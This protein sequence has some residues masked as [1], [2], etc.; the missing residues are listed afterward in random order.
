MGKQLAFVCQQ[1]VQTAIEGV[2]V[3]NGEVLS[4]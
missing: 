4:E 2:T 1:L 3:G